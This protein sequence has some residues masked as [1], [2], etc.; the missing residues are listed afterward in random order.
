[1]PVALS[2]LLA[3]IGAA[4]QPTA[5]PGLEQHELS[6]RDTVL[7]AMLLE[8]GQKH[9]F[10][11]WPDSPDDDDE[12]H[13]FFDQIS[14]LDQSYPGGITAYSASA[15]R[16]LAASKAGEN[17]MEG[18]VPSAPESGK[19][20]KFPSKQFFALEA[21]G[22]KEVKNLCFVLVAGGLGERLGYSGI[23]VALPSEI[24]TG[25]LYL[26][27]YAK[28]ILALQEMAGGGVKLPLAIMTSDDTDA[29][30]LAL[31]EEHGYFGLDKSQVTLMK[32][33]KVPA[34]F[35]NDAHIAPDKKTPYRVQ[36]KPHGHGDVH[37]LLHTTGLAK[38]WLDEGRKYILFF[39]DTNAL[40]FR[41]LLPALGVSAT[42][43]L[44]VNSVCVP[45]K[46]GEAVGALMHLEKGDQRQ[47][48]KA[49]VKKLTVNVEYN[50]I[51]A[52]LKDTGVSPDGDVNDPKTGFSP[53]PGSINQLIISIPEY[54]KVLGESGGLM[55]EFVNP[56]YADETKEK[57]KKPTRLE[58]MMQDYPRLLSR[59]AKVGFS[60]VA[61][62]KIFSP[63]KNNIVD[64]AKKYAAGVPPGSASTGEHDIYATNRRLLKS[65]GVELQGG[66]A[67]GEDA[68]EGAAKGGVAY[69]GIRVQSGAKVVLSP[70]F[71]MSVADL[72]THFPAPEQISISPTSSL[73]VNGAGVKIQ[74][75]ELDGALE[76]DAAPGVELTIE[77]LKVANKGIEFV[78]LP[79]DELAGGESPANEVLQLRGYKAI[80][81][82][83]KEIKVPNPGR[84]TYK[85]GGLWKL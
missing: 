27:L 7:A 36:T 68:V 72:R 14:A 37:L 22:A 45:R 53:Y 63:V 39:Q 35:N 17:P 61:G 29:P 78:P 30:T 40:V 57:F 58:T 41:S 70:S 18:F 23:K 3:S 83:V 77:E 81:H 10:E 47:P 60:S 76:I 55:P 13:E 67:G 38:K 26:E 25:T 48:N 33:E 8:A 51:D 69:A 19:T 74:S 71:A 64:A 42:L 34:V 79:D 56:K 73:A 49:G 84:Y 5:C 28:S 6:A 12:K 16:H 80:R 31:L 75:L 43:R 20:I 62:L 50:Q 46:A 44:Q 54:V 2:I 4:E 1:M 15:R 21:R 66:V 24:I 85:N 52:L 65:V 82:E 9:L 11:K 59:Y 32:Q